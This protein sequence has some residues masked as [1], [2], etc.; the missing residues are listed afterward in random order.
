MLN[1]LYKSIALLFLL[2]VMLAGLARA[3]GTAFTYQG[4]LTD[5]SNPADG[6]YDMQLKIFDN[7][8][9]GF[10]TQVGP[11]ITLSTVQV[12]NG[13]FTVLL[14]FGAGVFTGPTRFLEI[15]VRPTG[16]PAPYTILDPRQAI[17]TTPYALRA[18]TAGGAD[19]ATNATQLGGIGP[20][21][22][23]QNSTSQ[24]ASTSFNISGNGTLGGTLSAGTVNATTRFD[25]AGFR[26]LGADGNKNL[27]VGK[28]A[29]A[30]ITTGSENAFFGELAG[31]A[32]TAGGGNSFFG[33]SAGRLNTGN[34]NSFFGDKAGDANTTASNNSFFGAGAGFANTTGTS[35][36]FFGT[37]AG[38]A[39]TTASGNSFFGAFAGGA[40]VTGNSNAFFGSSSGSANTTG[41][42]N[43]FFGSG[44]G[45][46]NT[47]GI[48]NAFFGTNSGISNTTGS[49]NSFFGTLAGNSNSTANSNSF[50]G[51]ATGFSNT[52]GT[53]NSFFGSNAGST[54]TTGSNNSF[55]G[56]SAGGANT[57]G[58]FNTFVGYIAG[59]MNTTGT[60]NAFFG[61]QAGQKNSTASNNAFFGNAAGPINTTG[62]FNSF[63]GS[64]AGLSNETGSN[65]SFFGT[66]SGLNSTGADNSFFG[67][68]A[69]LNNL[70]GIANTFV[71]INAGDTNT[72]GDNNTAIGRD[73]DVGSNNL[74]N[75]T[76]I[77]ARAQV[78]QNNSLVLGSVNG[79]NG[80]TA[81][82]NVGIGTTAPTRALDV[83][84]G[85]GLSGHIQ[86][87]A[88][89]TTVA[90]RIII[91]GDSVCASGPCVSIGEQDANDRLVMKAAIFRFKSNGAG[92][93][94]PESNG[95]QNL[96]G[97]SNRW[98]AVWAT[99]GT[100]Q[101]S[102]ARLKREVTDLGYGLA[103]LMRLR[104]VTFF[105]KDQADTRRHVGLIA[106]EAETVI[107]ESVVRSNDPTAPIGM[108]YA[109]LVPVLIKAIQ[110]Q[111]RQIESLK[112]LACQGRANAD[113]C[114]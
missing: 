94:E 34:F 10:G 63:F 87:G 31:N 82:V 91:F 113:A 45:G 106:Q 38:V 70:G 55:F 27:F 77:G 8:A 80:A 109:D 24:Q 104:P 62:T 110:Q 47:A 46:L 112:A 108:N 64:G 88:P 53:S 49:N 11:T 96:G 71:G 111:Q 19:T 9:V 84:D 93:V 25:L 37:S 50:F 22:F 97:A 30:A 41:S 69:G 78:T 89:S 114:K 21:G 100:I 103:E 57:T 85:T 105:W 56:T 75:A 44:A 74:T 33:Y 28:N 79:I 72:E 83:R 39:N 58:G 29:G 15:G 67:V 59:Q 4:R 23:I 65:N 20:G 14:N 66:E 43:S 101:T 76:A 60:N 61:Y 48:G 13:V 107:P 86:I 17:T 81:S 68:R 1:K 6:M 92:H 42:S 95:T 99:N 90:D 36:S 73:A 35:N 16:S 40:N 51:A 102:D 2:I 3:Q 32:N 54:N 98:A 12:E 7:P 52:T 18:S 5:G 26:V